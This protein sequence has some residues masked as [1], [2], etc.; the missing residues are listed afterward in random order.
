VDAVEVLRVVQALEAAG[1]RYGLTGGWGIDALIGRQRRP[2][3][4]V[5]L[6]AAAEQVESVVALLAPL[7]YQVVLD[8]RPAR[9]E[10]E[11]PAGRVDLHPIR[12]DATGAGVQQGFDGVVYE[13]PLGSLDAI[14]WIAGVRVRCATPEL[15]RRFHEGYELTDRDRDDMAALTAARIDQRAG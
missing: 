8:Q 11:G 14:G 5:D 12:F 4:D 7:G 15:Q 13:Y 3:G 2:H 10:L 9:L 1:I 6:G